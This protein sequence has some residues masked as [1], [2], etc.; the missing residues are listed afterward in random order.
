MSCWFSYSQSILV[1]KG[2]MDGKDVH[3]KQR[4]EAG[5]ILQSGISF[6]FCYQYFERHSLLLQGLTDK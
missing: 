2:S 4:K 1:N 5:L 3:K 6:F